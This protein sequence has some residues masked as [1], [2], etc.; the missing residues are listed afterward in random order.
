[1]F[2][3]IVSDGV[4]PSSKEKKMKAI[5]TAIVMCIVTTTAYA[6]PYVEYKHENQHK[7]WKFDKNTEHLRLGYKAKNNLYF[8]LGPMT[9]G[10]SYE[11]GYKI[12]LNR[13][14]FK[15]KLE[16]KDI[17]TSKSKLETEIRYNF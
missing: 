4:K 2:S 16:T 6:G 7:D 5:I 3:F 15:G 1:M 8:E 12:K 13:F 17:G 11:A 9:N 14:T 10:H